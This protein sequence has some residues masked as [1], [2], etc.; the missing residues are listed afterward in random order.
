MIRPLA[1]FAALLAGLACSEPS[2]DA[3]AGAADASEDFVHEYATWP[4]PEPPGSYEIHP[5][6]TVL[7][8]IT[9]LMWQRNV[10]VGPGDGGGFVWSAAF[11]HCQNL[12]FAGYEDWRLPSRIELVSLVD[13]TRAEPAIAAETFPG[14]PA[15]WHWTSSL[16]VDPSNFAY[17]VNFFYG[18]TNSNDRVYS[19]QVRCVR[20]ARRAMQNP[21]ARYTLGDETVKDAAT[22]LEWQRAVSPE[23]LGWSDATAYCDELVAGNAADFRLPTMKELQTLIDERTFDPAIDSVAFPDTPSEQYWSSSTWSESPDQAWF[24]LFYDGYALYAAVT[25]QYRARCVR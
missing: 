12:A 9:G 19:Q 8:P 13:F 20:T 25:E 15:A 5:D 6:G 4:M 11:E 17:Y 21:A 14:T 23:R 16:S 22:G 3:P 7:D 2:A 1:P 18:Y 10:D 24:V